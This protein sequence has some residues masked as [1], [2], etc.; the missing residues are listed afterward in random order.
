M[1]QP[2][3][4]NPT[5]A[6]DREPSAWSRVEQRET[7]VDAAL[8]AVPSAID[9]LREINTSLQRLIEVAES[10]GTKGKAK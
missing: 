6:A 7:A 10:S 5:P 8:A 1:N 9:L 3:T 4:A 2:A